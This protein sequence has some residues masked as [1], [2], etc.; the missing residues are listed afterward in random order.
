MNY[1]D[2]VT[3]YFLNKYQS[4]LKYRHNFLSY[5]KIIFER[6]TK[7][8]STYANLGNVFRN[9]KWTDLKI[10]NIKIS[11]VKQFY[12]FILTLTF[13]IL[14]FTNNLPLV[15]FDILSI[16]SELFFN[17]LD[18]VSLTYVL[19]IYLIFPFTYNPQQVLTFKGSISENKPLSL[20]NCKST[21]YSSNTQ[22][23]KNLYGASYEINN[24]NTD[25]LL[26]ISKTKL[27]TTSN[28]N[29]NLSYAPELTTDNTLF[30]SSNNNLSLNKLNN[31]LHNKHFIFNSS[32]FS[33]DL[34]LMKSDRWLLKNSLVSEDFIRN[35]NS[36][37][38]TKKLIGSSLTNSQLSNKNVWASTNLTKLNQGNSSV[39]Q[40]G[41]LVLN[42]NSNNTNL[43]NS[44]LDNFNF[45]DT[46][47]NFLVN[48]YLFTNKLRYNNLVFSDDFIKSNKTNFNDGV[49]NFDLNYILFISSL[50][51]NIKLF[52]I[53]NLQSSKSLINSSVHT[54]SDLFF[55]NEEQNILN[56]T[57]LNNI[58]DLTSQ[59]SN[60][61]LWNSYFN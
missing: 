32:N 27:D 55:I 25:M 23:I 15:L 8:N 60:N 48:K 51:F 43:D 42:L 3:N 37:T 46:S 30:F 54:G 19:F 53:E 1:F 6:N 61:L 7:N 26:K 47:R 29:K 49:Q 39:A 18:F 34:D 52:F 36:Y 45:F 28:F 31:L 20:T 11:F 44:N 56:G 58:I 4:N 22:L 9:S 2:K 10:Q 40:I 21:D 35:T 16:G 57:N 41:S 14:S 38:L 5:L 59:K 13:I 33:K 24:L 50:D 17:L 12:L